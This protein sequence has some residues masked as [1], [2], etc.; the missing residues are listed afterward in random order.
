MEK[1]HPIN[2][3]MDSS[4]QNLRKLVDVN[5][6][7][8]DPIITENG[9]TIIP[10]SKVTFGFASGGSDFPTSK[11]A[12]LFGGASGG[13]VTIQPLGFLVVKED[14]VQLLQL[15][16]QNNTADRIVNMVPDVVDKVTGFFSKTGGEKTPP[17]GE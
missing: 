12:E 4:M 5:T 17:Q 7:I 2:G 9:T 16:G 8:G 1:Q 13:G 3:L 6:I 10:V 14:G 11:P 15:A